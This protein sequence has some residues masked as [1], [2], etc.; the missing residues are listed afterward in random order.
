MFAALAKRER[1]QVEVPRGIQPL[2][3]IVCHRKRP[4]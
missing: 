4:F 3:E 2:L 1:Q